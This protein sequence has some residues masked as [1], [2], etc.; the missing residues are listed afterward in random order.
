MTDR[1][2]PYDLK[3]TPTSEMGIVAETFWRMPGVLRT[4]HPT[5]AF[6]A[7]GP[8]AGE[9]TAEHPLE[10][11]EGINSP[12]GK[13]YQ[14]DGRILLVGVGHDANTTIH[15]GESLSN[16]PYRRIKT[17]RLL[18]NGQVMTRKIPFIDHCCQNFRKLGPVLRERGLV[19]TGLV[20]QAKAWLM[21]SRR[22]VEIT[23]ELLKSDPNLFL[24][25]PEAQC[26]QCD[27]ARDYAIL[28]SEI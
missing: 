10:N 7:R 5:S 16:V 21:R 6:A 14:F 19:R 8:L 25:P 1:R 4:M 3:Q 24:C 15:L 11:P 26:S 9:I 28:R 20:G 18:E 22:V 13:V 27:E 23:C 12:I 2:D 17:L